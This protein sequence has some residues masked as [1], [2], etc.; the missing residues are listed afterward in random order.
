LRAPADLQLHIRAVDLDMPDP[1]VEFISIPVDR[2][3]LGRDCILELDDWVEI[4]R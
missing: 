3:Q 1:E 4:C 2:W